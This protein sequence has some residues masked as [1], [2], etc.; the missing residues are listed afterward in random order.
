MNDDVLFYPE[1][2][3]KDEQQL[4]LLEKFKMFR[5]LVGEPHRIVYLRSL[6]RTRPFTRTVYPPGWK[7]NMNFTDKKYNLASQFRKDGKTESGQV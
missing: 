5:A 7:F 2:F 1:Y 4:S 6:L 3:P